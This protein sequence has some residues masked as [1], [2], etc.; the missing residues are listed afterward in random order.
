MSRAK[1]AK[2]QPKRAQLQDAITEAAKQLREAQEQLTA[3]TAF[4]FVG[5]D[6][7]R[8]DCGSEVDATEEI[9]I[10]LGES[11]IKLVE[12]V[13]PLVTAALSALGQDGG[14]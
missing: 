1:K 3:A 13:Q 9:R 7:L 2:A 4:L 6:A 5:M 8:P 10:V 11:Y 12:G 14:E